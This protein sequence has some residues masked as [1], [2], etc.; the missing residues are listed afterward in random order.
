[1]SGGISVWQSLN[2]SLPLPTSPALNLSGLR[3]AATQALAHL[4]LQ[5]PLFLQGLLQGQANPLG[6]GLWDDK[7][8]NKRERTM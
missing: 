2:A 4:L 7:V 5:K 6:L 8:L 1:M 3:L